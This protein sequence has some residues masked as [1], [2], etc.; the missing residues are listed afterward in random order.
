MKIS[1]FNEAQNLLTRLEAVK[2]QHH[3]LSVAYCAEEVDKILFQYSTGLNVTLF[4]R[5][6]LVK[7]ITH[8]TICVL[9]DEI[10]QLET[11]LVAMGFEL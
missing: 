6:D 2:R 8:L 7:K 4:R 3:D 1:R 10:K 5:A 11:E 9:D